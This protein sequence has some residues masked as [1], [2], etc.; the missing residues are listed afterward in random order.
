MF[1][2]FKGT[3]HLFSPLCNVISYCSSLINQV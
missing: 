1:P 3:T 2:S